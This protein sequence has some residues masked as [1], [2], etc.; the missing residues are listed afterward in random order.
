MELWL[1]LVVGLIGLI[2]LLLT[3][4]Y[5][6]LIKLFLKMWL[7][8]N[9]GGKFSIIFKEG[10]TFDL[11]V[12]VPDSTGRITI[13]EGD[14]ETKIQLNNDDV[15]WSNDAEAPA[16][17]VYTRR[18]A[19]LNPY[20]EKVKGVDPRVQALATMEAFNLGK[21]KGEKEEKWTFYIM[22]GALIASAIAAG[23]GILTLQLLNQMSS[24]PHV[25][26]GATKVAGTALKACLGC[27]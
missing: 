11:D 19:T 3:W 5:R 6:K 1:M 7:L 15:F 18:Q 16:T 21:Q 26:A 9:R 17:L 12:L 27:M 14:A 25:V 24:H 20:K 4:K 23:T 8:R 13:K 10:K 22:L 2:E